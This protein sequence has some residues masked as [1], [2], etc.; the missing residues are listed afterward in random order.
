MT[1]KRPSMAPG[2]EKWNAHYRV[3]WRPI[4]DWLMRSAAV[5]AGMQVLD[6]ACG[7]GQPAIPIADK[8]RPGGRVI[9]VDNDR[10]MLAAC[11]RLATIAGVDN[12]ELREMDMHALQFPDESFDAVT[13]SFAL[14]FAKDPVRV[15]SEIRRVL[16]P[17]GR[18]A[19]AVW[20]APARNAFFTTMFDA[21]E[22]LGPRPPVDPKAPGTFRLAP[23]GEL[24]SVIRAAG[25]QDFTVE[26][27]PVS[28]Y[29]ASPEEH[30]QMVVDMAGPIA[31]AV[32]TS[33]E[34]AAK[35]KAA[36]LDKLAEHVVEGRVKLTATPLCATA[37]R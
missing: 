36:L 21:L 2:W 14:M 15:M 35:V 27:L 13:M 19:L 11:R 25:F 33:P 29:S 22:A 28:F 8:V 23:H 30:W 34:A 20:G 24:Q 37:A 12:L 4:V 17:G 26:A 10:E 16:R 6:I 5:E 9:G 32:E 3:Q 18:F 1:A 7:V 31:T